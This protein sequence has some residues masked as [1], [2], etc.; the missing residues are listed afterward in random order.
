MNDQRVL[1]CRA[2]FV[3]KAI[4]GWAP[5]YTRC[6]QSFTAHSPL[7]TAFGDVYIYPQRPRVHA[8]ATPTLS[9]H[10]LASSVSTTMSG[11]SAPSKK[12]AN[13]TLDEILDRTIGVLNV[14]EDASDLIPVAG[15]GSAI[16]IV[17]KIVEQLRVS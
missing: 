7:R 12:K 13:S 6:V 9:P 1:M 15:I 14:L 17:R 10:S 11:S 2:I 8:R 4:V 16:P 5:I 3:F